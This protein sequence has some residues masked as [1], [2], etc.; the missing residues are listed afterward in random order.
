M[1]RGPV[2]C[3]S[4]TLHRP[5]RS[6]L[7]G[8]HQTARETQACL[9]ACS[10]QED[11]QHAL[12]GVLSTLPAPSDPAP[13]FRSPRNEPPSA[14]ATDGAPSTTLGR[15]SADSGWPELEVDDDDGDA[16][17]DVDGEVDEAE[18]GDDDDGGMGD[19]AA[20][21]K[22]GM[23]DIIG[24]AAPLL[25]LRDVS[26]LRQHEAWLRSQGLTLHSDTV[27]LA[28]EPDEE[29]NDG[30]HSRH[31]EGAKSAAVTAVHHTLPLTESNVLGV[32]LE[33][34]IVV[35]DVPRRVTDIGRSKVLL[36]W[37]GGELQPFLISG[38]PSIDA[39]QSAPA[40]PT[41][42]ELER[43]GRRDILAAIQVNPLALESTPPSR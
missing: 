20:G 19:M 29:S 42:Q 37:L 6:C 43:A 22:D 40:M 15:Q 41:R 23:P 32:D 28:N 3:P 12:E 21:Q 27:G 11:A 26:V 16:W 1:T 8:G 39:V 5:H 31:Q 18:E 9:G 33:F 38:G 10:V 36:E 30:K 25:V 14:S 24:G 34:G 13:E 35:L 2:Q 4:T 17:M 7:K